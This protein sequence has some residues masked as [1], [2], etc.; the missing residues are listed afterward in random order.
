MPKFKI[1]DSET[2][3]AVTVSGEYAPT[4]EEAEQIFKDAGLRNEQAPPMSLGDVAQGA[5]TNIPSSALNLA[6]NIGT[7]VMHPIDTGTSLVNAGRGAGQE[8]GNYVLGNHDAAPTPQTQ[9]FDGLKNYYGGRY[10]S[11]EGFKNAVA[12]DPVGI[13]AD[14]SMVA[15]GA[16]LAAKA[17][18]LTKAAALADRLG[19]ISN[20]IALAGKGIGAAANLGGKALAEALGVTTGAGGQSVRAAYG[21][22]LDGGS[23]SQAFASHMRGNAPIEEIVSDAH[24]ALGNLRNQRGAE[25]RAG[26]GGVNSDPA[27]LDLAPID[28][29]VSKAGSVNNFKGIDL[30]ES[31]GAV[32]QKIADK[33]EQWRGLDPQEYHTAAGFD[34]LKKSIGDIRDSAP[35]GTPERII[36]DQA[37][38]AVKDSIVQQAPEYGKTMQDYAKASD[39]L[40]DIQKTLSLGDKAATDTSIRK[41]QSSMWD[42]VNTSYGR[43][44]DLANVLAQNGAPD[45]MAKIAGQSLSSPTSRGLG[46][47]LMGGELGGGIATAAAG[48][49]ITAAAV[50]P[51]IAMQSPRL[52]GEAALATGKA[53]RLGQLL[54]K[55]VIRKPKSAA[56]AALIA[57]ELG[58]AQTSIG[59]R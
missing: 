38:N 52:V 28:A 59:N 7:A 51:A 20:P 42:N 21:A 33:I 9:A 31:T 15:G 50:L 53:A 27:I 39:Q 37:Y 13:A 36:A 6:K 54:A 16:G 2:G 30:S 48:H 4:H 24:N 45:L 46:K 1:T 17:G 19:T 40:A 57:D 41:L 5:I 47:M 26:M 12:T 56:D 58:A 18:G 35:Y 22:G 44:T 49:P 29:A 10:G 11:V 14:A 23:A 55:T 34:A 43:R 25:Y 3:K 8:L 32:R